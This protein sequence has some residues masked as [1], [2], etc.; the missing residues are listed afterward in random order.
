MKE[1]A[2][3][4]TKGEFNGYQEWYTTFDG[5]WYRGQYKNGVKIGYLEYHRFFKQTR[6]HIR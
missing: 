5:M 2:Q 3:L 1:I 6:F 4:N